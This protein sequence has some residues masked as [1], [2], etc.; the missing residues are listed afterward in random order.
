MNVRYSFTEAKD[1]V[2]SWRSFDH[3]FNPDRGFHLW[4]PGPG[5]FGSETERICN[6][7]RPDTPVPYLFTLLK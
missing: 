7:S 1:S 5:V 2:R 4:V 6:P 3:S